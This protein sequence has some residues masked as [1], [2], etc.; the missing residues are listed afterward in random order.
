MVFGRRRQQR[1][2]N[3]VDQRR[4]QRDMRHGGIVTAIINLILFRVFRFV[5]GCLLMIVI[6]GAFVAF[7][8]FSS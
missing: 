3:R 6:V 1:W 5:T 7:A 2:G 8:Y 4:F